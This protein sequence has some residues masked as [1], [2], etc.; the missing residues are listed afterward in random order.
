[1]VYANV[2]VGSCT[3]GC[4]TPK[5]TLEDH[6]Q[7][8]LQEEAR[9]ANQIMEKRKVESVLHGTTVK[10]LYRRDRAKKWHT[11]RTD[12]Y[13]QHMSKFEQYFD[14]TKDK[15]VS[16]NDINFQLRLHKEMNDF[17][18][19][20]K[21]GKKI[22]IATRTTDEEKYVPYKY[23]SEYVENPSYQDSRAVTSD[24]TKEIERR[25]HKR[26]TTTST[27]VSDDRLK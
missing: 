8:L 26:L 6:R 20:F 9:I 18:D 15:I 11:L 2:P 5:L 25:P 17:N 24:D 10:H 7:L 27:I 14:K 22:S 16:Q 23:G 4:T 21:L 13:H 3:K 19:A 1:M 12:Y